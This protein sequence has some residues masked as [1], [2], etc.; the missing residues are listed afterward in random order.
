VGAVEQAHAE[1]FS[2][3]EQAL[4]VEGGSFGQAMHMDME[5]AVAV[6]FHAP[7]PWGDTFSDTRLDGGNSDV[8]TQM[9]WRGTPVKEEPWDE[10]THATSPG[11]KPSV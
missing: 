11:Y 7:N 1:T 3:S 9:E 4:P 10:A 6:G 8:D 5:V 2:R